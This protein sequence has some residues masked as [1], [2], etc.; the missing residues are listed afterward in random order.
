MAEKCVN[1]GCPEVLRLALQDACS[2]APIAGVGNGMVMRCQRNVTIE[3][4]VRDADTSEFV[5]DCG[6]VD[7]YV[8]DAYVQ[9]YT[10]SFESARISPEL[11]AKLLG[12]D[13]LAIDGD[14]VG[15]IEE[16]A[17]GCTTQTVRPSFIAEA[18]YRV[19]QCDPTGNGD[20]MR[21]VIQGVKF[22]PV[23]TDKEGQIVYERYNGTSVPALT[24]GLVNPLS[25]TGG[26]YQDFPDDIVTELAAL[27]A[28]HLN[29]GL[30]F[31]DGIDSPTAGITLVAGTCYSATVPVDAP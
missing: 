9:G 24:A 30:R 8:Q 26:P 6:Q 7:E 4:R 11:Q 2:G 16:A 18:F 19:R 29:V 1:L 5:S 17:V 22:N 3:A 25:D 14:N 21:R 10:L 31:V 13:L 23:E 28:G 15:F 27:P 20:Y 12:Y